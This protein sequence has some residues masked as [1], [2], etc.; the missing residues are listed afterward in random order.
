MQS[1]KR[2]K[3]VLLHIGLGKTGT[4]AIQHTLLEG[5]ARLESELD[6]HY[7]VEF[8]DPRPFGGNHTLYLRS[9]FQP[10]G[11]TRRPNIIAGLGTPEALARANENLRRQF[12]AGF[13]K[14]NASRL[15]L[16]AEG[17]GHFSPAS[18]ANLKRW[19]DEITDD[20]KVIACLRHPRHALASET[21]QRLQTGALLRNMQLSPPYYSFERLFTDLEQF[22]S[23][24]AI[25]VYDYAEA[26]SSTL[27]ITG[28][29]LQKMGLEAGE[30]FKSSPVVNQAISHEATLLLDAINRLRPLVV[31]GEVNPRR[32][33]GD[34]QAILRI[35]GRKYVPDLEV[36]ELLDELV[37][38]DLEWLQQHYG[39]V[40]DAMGA[41][42]NATSG[43]TPGDF[44]I[45]AIDDLAL[46]MS[47]FANLR[48]R[49][50]QRIKK[51]RPPAT[52]K[53]LKPITLHI[54]MGKTGTT[55]L[56]RFFW[57]NRES[58]AER[59]IDYPVAGMAAHAHHLL[60]PHIPDGMRD[61]WEY[62]NVYQ[63]TAQM[64][65]SEHPQVLLSSEL[66]ISS[67]PA[68]IRHYFEVVCRHFRPRV[69]VY[70]RRQDHMIASLYNQLVKSGRQ[71]R[72][73][74][75]VL[76][77]QIKQHDYRHRL[78]PWEHVLGRDALL[79]RPYERQQLHGGD[80]RTDFMR[81][82]FDIEVDERFV[83]P[84]GDP[85]PGF[86]LEILEYKRCLNWVV[87]DRALHRQCNELL[88]EYLS[89]AETPDVAGT[90]VLGHDDR[91]AVLEALSESNARVARDYLGREDGQLF[92]EPLPTAEEGTAELQLTGEEA[93]AISS[94]IA[95]EDARLTR[96]LKSLLLEGRGSGGPYRQEAVEM[97]LTSFS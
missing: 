13:D 51:T 68:E 8:D 39:L 71:K 64:A 30:E 62:R 17:I 24:E 75:A 40:L 49:E 43:A 70:L 91:L 52:V 46:K 32:R 58:L 94:F 53:N 15:L 14:S 95:G 56:Q 36:Y 26:R 9:L 10:D 31:D 45:E 81:H 54:G 3:Q 7:P 42:D 89:R 69:V 63:W 18:L 25:T 6:I 28:L 19:L 44:S 82:V 80:I 11:E 96:E 57:E 48:G 74:A 73:L 78:K 88:Q 23:R 77:T 20:V 29:L 37:A 66:M 47:D 83:M 50:R 35:P 90:S 84:D 97:L 21:Q 55:V 4:T 85:N 16:S 76:P 87:K 67:T 1:G 22:F 86:P 34:T 61:R 2:F 41:G 38:P 33:Q 27:G 92:I 12:Q 65:E 79:V 93:A 60:S 5:A 72:P 59:G